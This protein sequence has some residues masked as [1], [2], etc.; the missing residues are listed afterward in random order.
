MGQEVGTSARL[1]HLELQSIVGSLGAGPFAVGT[2]I[3]KEYESF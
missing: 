3:N 2:A 1:C